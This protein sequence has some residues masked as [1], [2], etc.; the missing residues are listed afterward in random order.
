[1]VPPASSRGYQLTIL[2]TLQVANDDRRS[3]APPK[4]PPV[5]RPQAAV[6]RTPPKQP[7]V[8]RRVTPARGLLSVPCRQR[9]QMGTAFT[10][11]PIA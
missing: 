1:M 6:G 5:E 11:S 8:E 3:N 7:P 9:A 10:R 4:Q 2:H